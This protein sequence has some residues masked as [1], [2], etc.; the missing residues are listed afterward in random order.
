MVYRPRYGLSQTHYLKNRSRLT[1]RKRKKGN[2]MSFKPRALLLKIG[3]VRGIKLQCARWKNY[4]M[5]NFFGWELFSN[6]GSTAGTL[7]QCILQNFLIVVRTNIYRERKRVGEIEISARYM[8]LA[9]DLYNRS[10]VQQLCPSQIPVL[11]KKIR[12]FFKIRR[13]HRTE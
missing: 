6:G 12:S 13:P 10:V 1:H 7:G 4:L 5:A 11:E 3:Y 9:I 2:W 8:V